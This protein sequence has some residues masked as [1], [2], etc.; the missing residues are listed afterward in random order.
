MGGI[1]RPSWRRAQCR[2][3]RQAV[4]LFAVLRELPPICQASQA[5]HASGTSCRREAVHRLC[6]PHHCPD[7]W[8]P[9]SGAGQS[10][11]GRPG[12]VGLLLLH[13][14]AGTSGQ[15]LAGCDG[16]GTAL[17]WRRAPAHRPRQPARPGHPGR[18]LRAGAHRNGAR[19]R[20]PLRLLS[21]ARAR[22]PP[23]GQAQGR[24]ER[25]AGGALDP[26]APAQIPV[27]QRAGGQRRHCPP[28]AMA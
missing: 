3:P 24:I 6:G 17:L 7:R 10:L 5:L 8:G 4:A 19:L 23:A 22:L 12:G 26:G 11:R 13:G 15:G 9:G 28:A 25:T 16:T 18:S 14:H 27:R 21:A 1:L 2:P 20:P